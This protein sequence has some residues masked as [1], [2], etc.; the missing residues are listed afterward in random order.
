MARYYFQLSTVTPGTYV[1]L[2][3]ASGSTSPTAISPRDSAVVIPGSILR[4]DAT[5]GGLP[6]VAAGVATLYQKT[7]SA[8]GAV[9]ATATLTGTLVDG[10]DPGALPPLTFPQ[11]VNTSS[12]PPKLAGPNAWTGTQ[13]FTGATVTGISGGGSATVGTTAGTVAAGDDSRI[14]GAAQKSA[15]LSD[16]ASASTARTNLGLGTASTQATGTFLQAVNNLSDVTAATA[17]ANLGA[18]GI[19]EAV[20]VVATSGSAQTI[21]APTTATMHKYTLTANCTFTM[22]TATAGQ[23]FSVSL[24]QDATGSRTATFTGA[25]WAGGTAPT[26]STGASKIDDLVFQCTDATVGWKGYVAGLDMR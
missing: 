4:S 21:P 6:G 2:D 3:S 19:T 25:K 7:L 13:D 23:S 10:S 22:P 15:N 18:V 14:T 26:L 20:N 1:R 5:T 24:V 17:R 8:T 9:T 16:L 12:D 11:Q